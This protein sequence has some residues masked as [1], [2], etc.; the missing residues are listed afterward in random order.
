MGDGW[1]HFCIAKIGKLYQI[2][3]QHEGNTVMLS[4]K[5]VNGFEQNSVCG[6][7][8]SRFG[9]GFKINIF[10]IQASYI[11]NRSASSGQFSDLNKMTLYVST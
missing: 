7:N 10:H 9:G 2:E 5:N 4:L 1:Y 8:G 11:S 3:G 6:Y